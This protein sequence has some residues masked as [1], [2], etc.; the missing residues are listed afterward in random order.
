MIR[1]HTKKGF[2]DMSLYS[3]ADYGRQYMY[4]VAG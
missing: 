4:S 3:S 2:R 1:V